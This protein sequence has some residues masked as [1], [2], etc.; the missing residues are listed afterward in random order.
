MV[1]R[2]QFLRFFPL[3]T[4]L[5]QGAVKNVA[6]EEIPGWAR[7]FPVF[8]NALPNNEGGH[9]DS[10][11]LWDQES[12]G[13]WGNSRPRSALPMDGIVNAIALLWMVESGWRD[14]DHT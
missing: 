6:N 12:A 10:W 14:E 1:Q 3:R 13:G 9:F 5:R 7:Q 2:E 4:A 8:R 11:W